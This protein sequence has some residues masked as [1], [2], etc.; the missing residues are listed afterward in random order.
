MDCMLDMHMQFDFYEG[1]GLDLACLGMAQMDRHGNVNVSRFGPKLAGCGGFIDIS[2][3]SKK[4]VFV[5][6]FTA[7]KTQVAVADGTL[8]I[9]KEGGVKKFV[10]DVEDIR[11]QAEAI[12]SPLGRKVNAIVN[13][14]NRLLKSKVKRKL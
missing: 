6:T 3:N 4:M 7:G 14:D 5:G 8:R 13:Y 1:G 12:L 11:V 10:N 9:V 2:Q